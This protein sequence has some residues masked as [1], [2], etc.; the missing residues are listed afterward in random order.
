MCDVTAFTKEL[1][2]TKHC[3]ENDTDNNVILLKTHCKQ[4]DCLL[5]VWISLDTGVLVYKTHTSRTELMLHW[6]CWLL[7]VNKLFSYRLYG[8]V[9]TGKQKGGEKKRTQY[10][11][12]NNSSVCPS[13]FWF[14]VHITRFAAVFLLMTAWCRWPLTFY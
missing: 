8:P 13:S 11:L 7:Y 1:K 6:T 10:R 5:F 4:P 9:Y 12:W 14:V 3:L 2:K